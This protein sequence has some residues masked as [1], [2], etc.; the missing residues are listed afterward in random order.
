MK[1]HYKFVFERISILSVIASAPQRSNLIPLS[2]RLLRQKTPRNDRYKD[3]IGFRSS[4]KFNLSPLIFLFALLLPISIFAQNDYP[5]LVDVTKKVGINFIHSFGD[6]EMTNIMES[7]TS[8]CAFFDYDGDGDVDIYLVNGAYIKGLS[9]IS[10][11]KNRNKLFN[12]LYRN[13]GDGTFTDVT[14]ESGAGHIGLGM[15]VVT[16]DYDN[17]GDQDIFLSNYGPNIFYRNNGNGT[18]TDITAEAG[19][20]NDLFSIGSTFLDYDLDGYLDL[21]VGNYIEYDPDYQYFYAAR[22]FP[23]PLAYHGQPDV[24]YHNNGDGTFTDVTKQAGVFNP[25]GR[26]MGVNSCDL[27]DDGD[28][29]IYVANDATEN[30]LY[31]NNGDGTFTNIA[32]QTATG[33]SQGGEATSSMCGEFGDFDLDGFIDI[34]VPDLSYGCLYKNTGEGYFDEMSASMGLATVAGQYTSWSSNFFDFN[35]DGFG[36]L[37]ISNG[38]PHRLIKQEDLILIN[39]NGTRLENI[40]HELGPDFQEKFASRGSAVGDYDDDGDMDI[41]ILNMN[42]RARLLMNDGGNKKNWIKIFLVGT[43]SNRDAIGSKVQITTGNQIQTRWRVSSSGYL[44]Q[45]DHRIHFGLGDYA[46]I[47]KI[48]IRWPSQKT[49]ILENVKVNQTI[50]IKEL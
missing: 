32:L 29:D 45:S 4:T 2:R 19:L 40:S 42:D 44:S 37:F 43:T 18:F 41:L 34:T 3:F 14:A 47:D 1:Y 39:K 17:D 23:G 11:R 21:Y 35:H 26:A 36:D 25:E 48:E 13:K 50:T 12:T 10:G 33:F 22:K 8:G 16:G 20:E 28:W 27:D 49:Q 15:A 31:S 6:D 5:K 46:E 38:H 30:F 24:L 7:N 9:H